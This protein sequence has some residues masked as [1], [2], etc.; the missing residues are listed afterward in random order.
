MID[1]AGHHRRLALVEDLAGDVVAEV[2]SPSAERV[3]RMPVATEISSAGIC[4][5]RPSP[6]VSSEK[7]WAGLAERHALLRRRR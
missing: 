5:H 2:A 4:A 3:T 7:C 1:R 6:T